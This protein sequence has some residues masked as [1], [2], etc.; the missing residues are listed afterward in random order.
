M[1][2][3]RFRFE[4]A[5]QRK[6]KALGFRTEWVRFLL[7]FFATLWCCS[8]FAGLLLVVSPVWC[9]ILRCY[10]TSASPRV[11]FTFAAPIPFFEGPS[12]PSS[13]SLPYSHI[14]RNYV[15]ACINY[16][17]VSV[18]RS[19]ARFLRGVRRRHRQFRTLEILSPPTEI[20]PLTPITPTLSL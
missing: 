15:S 5:P 2:M 7:G 12:R 3:T 19:P 20:Y 17:L 16:F 18:S 10:I 1:G 8:F 14:L 4:A 13:P 9:C 6:I 11:D